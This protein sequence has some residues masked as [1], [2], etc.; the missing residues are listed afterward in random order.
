ML[1]T[2]SLSELIFPISELILP[3]SELILPFSELNLS[4]S[5]KL[6][7][8][9]FLMTLRQKVGIDLEHFYSLYL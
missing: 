7:S 6:N 1:R 3:I 8:F 4:V 5:L 9:P 2:L